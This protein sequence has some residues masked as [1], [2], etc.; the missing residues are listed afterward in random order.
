M[1]EELKENKMGREP[2]HGLLIKMALPM[3]ISMFVQ[4]L[5]NVVDSIFVARIGEDALSAV[6]IT[7]PIQMLMISVA[8]GTGIGMSA[9]LSRFLGAKDYKRVNSVAQ[10]GLF[11]ALMS[12]IFFFMVSFG[13]RSFM[14]FQID[15][16]ILL[17]LARHILQ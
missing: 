4:S 12:Y 11:L 13:A 8:I 1:K 7:F 15:D 3:M 6:S 14:A 5:Y 17:S 9:L 2:V 16:K 10:N